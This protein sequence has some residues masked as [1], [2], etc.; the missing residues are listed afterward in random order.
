[1]QA[2]EYLQKS[3]NSFFKQRE[4]IRIKKII[5]PYENW[6]ATNFD[7]NDKTV[8]DFGCNV[9]SL[10]YKRTKR[11]KNVTYKGFDLDEDTINW[12][13]QNSYYEDFWHTH[14]KFH[15]I[16]ATQVYEH[17]DIQQR[18]DF[19]AHCLELLTDDG[20]LLLDFPFIENLNGLR[21][22]HDLTHKPVSSKDDPLLVKNSGF[23]EVET[24]LVGSP[25]LN[26]FL[27][28][29]N[30]LIFGNWH[31]TQQIVAY[32]HSKV[33]NTFNNV[34]SSWSEHLII[35]P[36]EI[37]FNLFKETTNKVILEAG[38][39]EGNLCRY[40]QS[41]GNTVYGIDISDNL[42]SAA[43]NY[44]DS[45]SYEVGDVRSLPYKD[46]TFDLVYS[47]G[48]IE[49]FDGTELA[50]KEMV[51]V[52]KPG[53]E[54]L[55]GV[56]NKYSFQYPIVYILQK[57]NKYNLGYEKAYTFEWLQNQLLQNGVTQVSRISVHAI[58]SLK[59]YTLPKKII[60]TIIK[61]LD[62]LPYKLGFGGF[63][64]YAKCTK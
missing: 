2:N 41:L 5:S 52:T 39:G 57:L 28:L 43:K 63:F 11:Y 12:L 34:A 51:R 29:L 31:Q 30:I 8:L 18:L 64:F 14:N 54:L 48:V 56:P 49:H 1:M 60:L 7:L 27:Y 55:I 46:D 25:P 13:K 35:D 59:E 61:I 37:P 6:F 50:I 10:F 9:E 23:G 45:I 21:F 38:C 53:G 62:Y 32:K 58:Q 17:L 36:N 16:N 19:C 40:L 22:W 24:F 3:Y 44:N 4:S 33:K 15:I 26:F 20:I 42:V 47:G